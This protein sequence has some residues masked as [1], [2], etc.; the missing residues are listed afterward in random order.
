MTRTHVTLALLAAVALGAYLAPQLRA[1]STPAPPPAQAP[2]GGADPA[3]SISS[4][5]TFEA[6]IDITSAPLGLPSERFLVVTLRAPASSAPPSPVA[7]AVVLDTSGS[8]M[9]SDKLSVARGAVEQL[10]AAMRPEDRIA[11]VSFSDQ[12]R[13]L[14]PVTSAADLPAIQAALA[15]LRAEGGTNLY[16]GLERGG[17]ELAAARQP[18]QISRILLISDGQANVG[19]TE[20]YAIARLAA[21]L[22]QEGTTVTGL[23]LG[24]DYKEDLLAQVSDFGGG[25][26]HFVEDPNHLVALFQEEWAQSGATVA[27]NLSLSLEQRPGLESVSWVGWDTSRAEA[28]LTLALGS[29][30]AGEQRRVVG[31]L[32]VRAD[33]PGPFTAANLTL[34]YTDVLTGHSERITRA[35]LAEGVT[36]PAAVEDS[37]HPETATAAR[38]AYGNWFLD[39]STR[40]YAAGDRAEAAALASRG[41]TVLNEAAEALEQPYLRDD[42]RELSALGEGFQVYSTE[43]DEGKRLMKAG[44]ERMRER[45]R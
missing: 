40:A 35:L 11:L 22:H 41:A 20:P 26:Y 12:A 21:A 23:G 37:I 9:D 30:R 44:K 27:H 45:T 2:S 7:L 18:G 38:R 8:M 14:L 5:L 29:L 31:R 4:N 3:P 28:P 17:R 13:T 25:N 42:A 33:N 15:G 34:T 6:D 19:V 16:D 39:L 32:Q 43:S 10:A 24:L 1:A 36:D